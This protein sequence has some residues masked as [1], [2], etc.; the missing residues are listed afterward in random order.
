MSFWRT[1]CAHLTDH[2]TDLI[3]HSEVLDYSVGD[4][5]SEC[6]PLSNVRLRQLIFTHRSETDIEDYLRK[7]K[8]EETF[9]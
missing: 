2:V 1:G 3:I 5:C 4:C 8:T 9:I 7:A 6:P